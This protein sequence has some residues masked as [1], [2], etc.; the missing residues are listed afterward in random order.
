MCAGGDEYPFVD[1]WSAEV[2]VKSQFIHTEEVELVLDTVVSKYDWTKIYTMV[3][4]AVAL[5]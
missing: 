4:F 2:S 1:Q 5:G 3:D